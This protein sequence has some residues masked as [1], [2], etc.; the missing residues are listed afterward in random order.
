MFNWKGLPNKSTMLEQLDTMRE[1]AMTVTSGE[2]PNAFGHLIIVLRDVSTGEEKAHALLFDKE[3]L[4]STNSDEENR[5]K[6]RNV[7]R[8]K[9][10]ESF[11]S[12][13][14]V[15][16][17]RPHP[18]IGGESVLTDH[19]RRSAITFWN[20]VLHTCLTRRC[21]SWLYELER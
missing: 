19:P 4:E 16:V 14:V 15:C 21:I 2:R 10:E 12:K 20:V 9:L 3:N 1:A 13:R 8:D 7:I 6:A 11:Q 5:K 17:P 18:E